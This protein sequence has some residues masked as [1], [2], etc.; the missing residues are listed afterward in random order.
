MY[1]LSKQ[2]TYQ[3][4]NFKFEKFSTSLVAAILAEKI[5]TIKNIHSQFD[6]WW[7]KSLNLQKFFK[8]MSLSLAWSIKT[9]FVGFQRWSQQYTQD[10]SPI[11][12]YI[13][14]LPEATVLKIRI[15][16]VVLEYLFV[17]IHRYKVFLSE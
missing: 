11:L 14:R 17:D 8:I 3:M 16:K 1:A 5:N 13:L 2:R 4:N 6:N 15:I 7:G 9:L 12:R 10:K